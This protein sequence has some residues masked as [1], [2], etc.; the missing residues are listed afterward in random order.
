LA[1]VVIRSASEQN[2]L[3]GQLGGAIQDAG[4]EVW[5]ADGYDDDFWHSG[6][7]VE[8]IRSANAAVVIWSEDAASS[9]LICD[10]ANAARQQSKLI[11][12][13]ADGRAPPAPFDRAPV[14]HLSGWRGEPGH[15]GWRQILTQLEAMTA[16]RGGAKAKRQIANAL[17]SLTLPS[18]AVPLRLR[19]D[20]ALA[21]PSPDAPTIA[22]SSR[23]EPRTAL[24]LLALTGAAGAAG[25]LGGRQQGLSESAEMAA[26]AP[27]N[28]G[29]MMVLSARS[30]GLPKPPTAAR[31]PSA[32]RPSAPV[33]TASPAQAVL[34]APAGSAAAI[35]SEPPR[36]TKVTAASRTKT[37]DAAVRKRS[38]AAATIKPTVR[39]KP[40]LKTKAAVKRAQPRIKYRYSETMRL[41]CQGA[42]KATPECRIFRRNAPRSRR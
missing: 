19:S 13:S 32:T 21:L 26:A 14:A 6:D 38:P 20:A 27:A 28:A 9:A 7:V 11:Q 12:V 8:R 33:R 25:W 34:A 39:S 16:S 36:Q 15:P 29:K 41:F 23:F 31:P 24:L 10:E 37:S 5:R 17:R 40:A 18:L 4:F 30:S 35:A 1:D 2:E 3:A 22:R 42:G